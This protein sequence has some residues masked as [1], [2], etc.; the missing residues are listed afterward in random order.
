MSDDID[1][2][3]RGRFAIVGEIGRGVVLEPAVEGRENTESVG[4]G[5]SCA[6]DNGR[7]ANGV[8]G[9]RFIEEGEPY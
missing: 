6:V 2:L 1:A 4:D 7:P 5:G 8:V 3:F 9:E